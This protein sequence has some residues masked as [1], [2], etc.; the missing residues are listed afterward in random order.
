MFSALNSSFSS[1]VSRP[2]KDPKISFE[3]VRHLKL[4]DKKLKLNSAKNFKG[5]WRL[6]LLVKYCFKF[7]FVAKVYSHSSKLH[8]YFN[9]FYFNNSLT[10]KTLDLSIFFVT[11]KHKVPI[12]LKKGFRMELIKVHNGV[13][14]S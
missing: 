10:L 1:I 9:V 4:K 2:E 3:R 14:T 13:P 7:H 12:Y 6:K 8:L 11:F 5:N